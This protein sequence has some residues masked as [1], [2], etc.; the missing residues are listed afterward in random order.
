MGFLSAINSCN[1][2]PIYNAPWNMPTTAYP[3][4]DYTVPMFYN[5]ELMSYFNYL[6]TASQNNYYKNPFLNNTYFF[7]TKADDNFSLTKKTD[8]SSKAEKA[9]EIAERELKKGVNENLGKNDGSE[10]RKYKN[11]AKN[12]VPWCASFTSYCYGEGQGSSNKNTFGYNASSQE[13]R[14]KADRNGY[15]A[16]KNSGY[17]PQKGDLAVWKYSE[18]SGHIGIVSKVYD[19]GS[20]DVIQGNSKNRVRKIHYESPNLVSDSFNGFVKMNEWLA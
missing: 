4:S 2:E 3:V 17:T 6:N 7:N 14:R 1:T 20:F 13:I 9:V 5:Q 11:G 12:D 16:K 15:Y 19:N 10:I 18:N 8:T